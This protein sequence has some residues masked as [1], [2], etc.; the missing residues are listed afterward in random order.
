MTQQEIE[1]FVLELENVER[2]EN[3]GYIFFFVGDYHMI[4]FTT[5][6]YADNEGDKVS[7]LNRKGVFRV[8]IG[9]SKETFD[10]LFP[11]YSPENNVDYTALDTF[12]PHP[13]YAAQS[14]ICILNP[15]SKN[16]ESV[17]K[18]ISEAHSIAKKLN[19]IRKSS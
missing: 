19:E 3:M 4:P 13:H 6:G 14:Y 5:I 15:S 2:E 16:E 9:V 18:Y 7:N 1:K 10:S 17:K 8:N 11:N 12:M